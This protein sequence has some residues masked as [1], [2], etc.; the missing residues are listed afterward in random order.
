VNDA[1]T[2]F[3]GLT[4]KTYISELQKK[5]DEDKKAREKL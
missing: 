5:L 2:Q 4:G 3:T 1:L